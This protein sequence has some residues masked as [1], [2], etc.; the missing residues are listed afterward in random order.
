MKT[1]HE[2]QDVRE[3]RSE[4]ATPYLVVIAIGIVCFV[5]VPAVRLLIDW[6]GL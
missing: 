6:M 2:L 3:G 4:T 5:I 1:D